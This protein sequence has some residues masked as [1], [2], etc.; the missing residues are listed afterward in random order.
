MKNFI[1]ITIMILATFF[2]SG[3]LTAKEWS[4]LPQNYV[5]EINLN[6]YLRDRNE[7]S[8]TDKP[9][10][11]KKDFD[12]PLLNTQDFGNACTY[13]NKLNGY[14]LLGEHNDKQASNFNSISKTN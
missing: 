9:F 2:L 4:Y 1:V 13:D 14:S 11:R 10:C 5:S 12:Y 6:D 3:N 7:F 8:Y